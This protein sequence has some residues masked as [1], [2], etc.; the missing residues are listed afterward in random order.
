MSKDPSTAAT[1]AVVP[2]SVVTVPH[3]GE[4]HH[5]IPTAVFFVSGKGDQDL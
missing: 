3:S 2:D 5:G 4:K 1:A